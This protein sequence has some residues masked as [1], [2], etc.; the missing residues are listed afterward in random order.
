MLIILL[1]SLLMIMATLLPLSHIKVWWVRIFDFPRPQI[2]VISGILLVA[3]GLYGPSNALE[4]LIATTLLLCLLWQ[5]AKIL[6][7]SLLY[8]TEVE[9]ANQPAGDNEIKLL[10]ANVLMTNQQP[11][12][13]IKLIKQYDP[14]IV[15][16]LETNQYWEKQLAELEPSYPYVVRCPQEN[17][18]GMHLYSKFT[19]LNPQIQFLVEEQVPSIH[20][21]VR[22]RSSMLIRLH[23]LHPAPPSPTENEKSL[24]RDVE[25]IKVARNVRENSQPTVVIGDLND[26]VWSAT[27]LMFK[28]ISRLLD[29]RI[30]RGFFNTFDARYF[31]LRWP[32]D[33]LFHSKEFKVVT[34]KRLPFIGSDHFPIFCHYISAHIAATKSG[35]GIPF[36]RSFGFK[37]TGAYT[38][39]ANQ[40]WSKI[41]TQGISKSQ[42]NT[43]AGEGINITDTKAK[44]WCNIDIFR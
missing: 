34:I 6:P 13:L 26:V 36:K 7:C 12:L 3:I 9:N 18:Y 32:L 33:H 16:T 23:C 15:L 21:D 22:L 10:S 24:E 44:L 41:F 40:W 29:P 25:L 42:H 20:T 39:W 27:T 19:L 37:V 35:K 4:W 30:G 28:K 5:L 38:T 8:P 31:F 2:A 17:L 11:Q 1:V 14:D 43:S